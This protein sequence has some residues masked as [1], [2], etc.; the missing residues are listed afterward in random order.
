MG[1]LGEKNAAQTGQYRWLERL[2]RKRQR[3]GPTARSGMFGGTAVSKG[4]DK[5]PG[6][7]VT[8]GIGWITGEGGLGS[9]CWPA[10]PTGSERRGGGAAV[11][12]DGAGPGGHAAA[13]GGDGPR[14]PGA[15]AGPVGGGPQAADGRP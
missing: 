2:G 7:V 10:F 8:G 13:G 12:A 11:N 9:L 1:S 14:R 3:E 5:A 6:K 4:E 15:A